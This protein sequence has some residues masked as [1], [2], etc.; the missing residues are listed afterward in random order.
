MI[1]RYNEKCERQRFTNINRGLFFLLFC[2]C[3][4]REGCACLVAEISQQK[5]ENNN[6][7]QKIPPTHPR[8]GRKNHKPCFYNKRSRLP[9]G[10]FQLRRG[11]PEGVGYLVTPRLFKV[12][13]IF[14]QPPAERGNLAPGEPGGRGRCR[15]GAKAYNSLTVG[16]QAARKIAKSERYSLRAS[17]IEMLALFK[18]AR[19]NRRIVRSSIF[20]ADLFALPIGSGRHSLAFTSA[21]SAR[22]FTIFH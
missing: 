9:E 11:R 3:D 6:P 14:P 22:D 8:E 15:S 2:V 7:Q 12:G 13:G 10:D 5:K 4:F 19:A 16:T 17:R 1:N 18:A 20:R 21:V